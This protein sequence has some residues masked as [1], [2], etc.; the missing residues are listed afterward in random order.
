LPFAAWTA[1]VGRVA[2]AIREGGAMGDK[3]QKAK[4]RNQR[5]KDAARTQ[6]E[7]AAKSKQEG[8]NHGPQ[9][10]QKGKK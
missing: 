6:G 7:A 5:Q 3:S 1:I 4:Q 2:R 8:Q 9:F 10:M